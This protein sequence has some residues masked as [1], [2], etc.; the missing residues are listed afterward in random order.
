MKMSDYTLDPKAANQADVIFSKIE[1]AGKYLGQITRAEAVT[2]KK[3]T[4][5]VDLSFKADSGETADYLTL[6]T[7]NADGKQIMGFNTL[8]AIM[9]CLRVKT[10]TAESGLIEKYDQDLQK[11]VK[12]EVPLFKDLMGKPI[13]L[14][15]HME[16]YAK[17]SGG[18]AWKPVISAAFD[19]D[20]F[21]ASE[22]LNKSI[23][24]VTL[25]KMVQ[26]L[27]DKPLK[28]YAVV[29]R[30]DSENPAPTGGFADNFDSDLS[31]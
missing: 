18:T 1:Q 8:M 16:E 11:R 7:Y 17:T 4:K 22:I 26:A 12:V 24:P 19:K 9:T 13:G 25:A 2:S 29:A 27:R 21:T 23:K 6:W 10:L 20:E 5:G 31:F 28:A 14:L 15:M 30:I 3:G